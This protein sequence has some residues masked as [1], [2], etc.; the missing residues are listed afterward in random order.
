MQQPDLFTYTPRP[1]YPDYPGH[2][3]VDTSMEAAKSIASGLND[4]QLRVLGAIKN[5]GACGATTE[6]LEGLTGVPY[7]TCQPRTSELRKK[8]LIADKGKRRKNAGGQ[9]VKVWEAV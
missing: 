3:G 8:G 7:K 1:R 4:L 6:E 2:R 9:N 5:Q